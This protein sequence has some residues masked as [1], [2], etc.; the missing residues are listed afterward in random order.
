M[1]FVCIHGHFYQ[2]PREDPLTGVVPVERSAAPYANWNE[3]ITAECYRVNAAARIMDAVTGDVANRVNNYAWIS[4]NFGP[5]LMAWLQR[6]APDVHA[7]IVDA[8]K[9]SAARWGHGNAIAQSMHHAILPLCSPRDRRTEVRW[10]VDDFTHRFGR[11]PEGMWL[12]ES[13]VDAASLETLVDH[14]IRF[15]IL[16]PR[17]CRAVA[18]P[19]HGWVNVNERQLDTRRPYRIE[20]PS[21]RSIAAFFYDGQ[22]SQGVAFEGL[23]DDGTRF[24]DRLAGTLGHRPHEAQLSHI[25]TDGESYGHHHAFGEMALAYAIRVLR[26]RPDVALTNYAGFLA[27]HPPT[28]RAALR[29]PS[30]WSCAHG[31]ERWRSDC[32]CALAPGPPGSQAW[33]TPLRDAF[34]WLRDE[35]Y[36]TY[37]RVVGAHVADPWALRDALH[38]AA[39]RGEDAVDELLTRSASSRLGNKARATV[40]DALE[41]QRLALT[42]F[43][44]CGWFFDHPSDIGTRNDMKAAGE[45]ARRAEALGGPE[46]LDELERRLA[47]VEGA[48]SA[49]RRAA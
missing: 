26:G 27:A 28:W 34:N 35:V 47:G 44:S 39:L 43:T 3:R 18:A 37:D 17:Q 10:G 7:S 46:L 19:G 9:E 11:A 6:N 24:A 20:L 12:P 45:V 22:V 23:L 40:R 33:R 48:H 30:S 21:G 41:M 4:F 8:D 49:I 2:P 42:M 29:E 5:T 15:V 32:G 38:A 14:D 16:A 31:V 25:A 1:R 36:T 13:A